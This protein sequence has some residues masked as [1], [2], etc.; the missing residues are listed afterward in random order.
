MIDPINHVPSHATV[1]SPR[2]ERGFVTASSTVAALR[3]SE[4]SLSCYVAVDHVLI[5]TLIT[6]V[7]TSLITS[8]SRPT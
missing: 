1:M 8:Q 3:R 7:I 4:L 5:T 6:S 2:H